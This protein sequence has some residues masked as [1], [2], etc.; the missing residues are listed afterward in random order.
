MAAKPY[1]IQYSNDAVEDVRALRAYDQRKIV[2]A[3]ETHLSHVP[4]QVSR[5]SIKR[6]VQPFWS[7]FRL[8]VEDFR[9]YYDVDETTRV[10]S[11]LRVL[12]KGTSETPESA[13][14]EDH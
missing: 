8:R 4:T 1:E 10:V 13:S 7:Q 2:T 11:V 5:T 12:E 6:M 9:V 14:H 3:I